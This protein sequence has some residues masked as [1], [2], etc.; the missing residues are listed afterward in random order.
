MKVE[1]R[2]PSHQPSRFEYLRVAASF[3]GSLE[4]KVPRNDPR[5]RDINRHRAATD[6]PGL[7]GSDDIRSRSGQ[8]SET[9]QPIRDNHSGA[10]EIQDA[11]SSPF[12]SKRPEHEGDLALLGVGQRSKRWIALEE[13]PPHSR[14][15]LRSRADKHQLRDHEAVGVSFIPPREISPR[16]T[17]PPEER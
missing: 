5:D 17:G 2:S 4:S 16:A 6:D 1:A 11:P 9:A 10:S 3:P 13:G 12:K 14:D 7:C 15:L 8:G